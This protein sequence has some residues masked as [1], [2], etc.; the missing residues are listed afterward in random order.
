M[1]RDTQKV[2]QYLNHLNVIIKL[3]KALFL[4]KAT[5]YLIRPKSFRLQCQAFD[6]HECTG[7]VP[8]LHQQRAFANPDAKR[9]RQISIVTVFFL[10]FLELLKIENI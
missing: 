8:I 1:G 3:V 6:F 5:R 10:R 7:E 2:T 4:S 9:T